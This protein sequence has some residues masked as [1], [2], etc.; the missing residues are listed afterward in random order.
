M[1]FSLFSKSRFI[2][3]LKTGPVMRVSANGVEH[4]RRSYSMF[5]T[6]RKP[7]TTDRVNITPAVVLGVWRRSVISSENLGRETKSGYLALEWGVWHFVLNFLKTSCNKTDAEVESDKAEILK[8]LSDQA[9]FYD[10]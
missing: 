1:K 9:K 10:E 4:Y 5:F 8:R 7:S 3:T 6:Y 2:P